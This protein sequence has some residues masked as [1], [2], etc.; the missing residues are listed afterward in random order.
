MLQYQ[1]NAAILPIVLGE[2]KATMESNSAVVIKWNTLSEINNKNFIVERSADGNNFTLLDN[3]AATNETNGHAYSLID[4]KPL[5]GNNFYRLA[6]VDIDGKI[7]YFNILKVV[8][9]VSAN[10]LYFQLMPNPVVNTM[11]IE[12]LNP[13]KGTLQVILTDIQGQQVRTWNFQKTNPF[14]EQSIDVSGIP[15]G[16]YILQVK[17]NNISEV[18]RFIK[19]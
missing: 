12:M 17:G 13:S 9:P 19:Q 6:Q 1:T 14:W 11:R 7:T 2:Y 16:N 4:G 5:P 10:Q 8:N 18:K 3:V 15:K